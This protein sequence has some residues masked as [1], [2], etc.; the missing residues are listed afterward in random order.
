MKD[1]TVP[2][3]SRLNLL[4]SFFSPAVFGLWPL[5]PSQLLVQ[6]LLFSFHLFLSPL[7]LVHSLFLVSA[8]FLASTYLQNLC[9]PL[10]WTAR[11]NLQPFLYLL[12]CRSQ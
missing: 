11:T 10:Q 9:L 8:I 12:L 4:E 3:Q 1:E 2:R 7:V 6:V 5:H